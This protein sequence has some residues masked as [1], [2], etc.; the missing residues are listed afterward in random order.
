MKA[1]LVVDECDFLSEASD[2]LL[3]DSTVL[4]LNSQN[5]YRKSKDVGTT[6]TVLIY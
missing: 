1:R 3:R 6:V 5:V 2:G 4:G